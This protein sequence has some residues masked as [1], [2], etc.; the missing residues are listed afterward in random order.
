VN[1]SHARKFPSSDSLS[2]RDELERSKID[3][4]LTEY[5]A[6]EGYQLDRRASSRNSVVMRH[7]GADKIIIGR[8]ETQHWI[9]FSV[10]DDTDNG[11]IIDCI[12]HRRRCSIGEVRRKLRL[13][14]RGRLPDGPCGYEINYRGF[15]GFASGR[16][17]SVV[18]RRQGRGHRPGDRGERYRRPALGGERPVRQHRRRYD[19]HSARPDPRRPR[20]DGVEGRPSSSPPTTM[21]AAEHIA[22]LAEETG[23]ADLQMVRDLPEGEGS[24]RN[25]RLTASQGIAP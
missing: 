2:G 22:V 21:P 10:R 4:N 25:D 13:G 20:E 1:F 16:E 15:T 5:G 17:G 14:R 19:P 23:L 11:S 8:G 18:F 7:L 12:Q 9:Y 24:D 6:T 3:I